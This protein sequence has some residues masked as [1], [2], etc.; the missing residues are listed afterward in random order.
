MNDYM[1][2]MFKHA[3]NGTILTGDDFQRL[4]IKRLRDGRV[5]ASMNA[6]MFN[7]CDTY[8]KHETGW[9]K[10]EPHH[11]KIPKHIAAMVMEEISDEQNGISI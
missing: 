2:S 11:V 6:N 1:N 4:H 10:I 7:V 8:I 3:K 9:I 5:D